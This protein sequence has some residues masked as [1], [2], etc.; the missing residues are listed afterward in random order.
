MSLGGWLVGWAFLSGMILMGGLL[1]LLILGLAL[2][3]P[4]YW[5]T[6]A[7]ES[8]LWGDMALAVLLEAG[9]LALLVLAVLAVASHGPLGDVRPAPGPAHCQQAPL[10]LAPAAAGGT[11]PALVGCQSGTA[12]LRG[13]QRASAATI[14]IRRP[15]SAHYAAI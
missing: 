6:T 8:G 12:R 14:A 15:F 11:V 5:A 1:W 9:L 4:V 7:L 2:C 3:L 10:R 13:H